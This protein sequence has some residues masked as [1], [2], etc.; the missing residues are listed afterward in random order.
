MP[1]TEEDSSR[2]WLRSRTREWEIIGDA[3]DVDY[4]DGDDQAKHSDEDMSRFKIS[5]KR[6]YQYS[7]DDLKIDIKIGIPTCN[8]VVH[9]D[10]LDN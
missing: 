10:E 3:E 6:L 9:V 4:E 1:T 8:D 7:M 5:N 2:S